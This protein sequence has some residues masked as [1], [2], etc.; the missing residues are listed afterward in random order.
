[1]C[2]VLHMYMYV[3]QKSMTVKVSVVSMVPRAL[4][5]STRLLVDVTLALLASS[6][7]QVQTLVLNVSVCRNRST[8]VNAVCLIPTYCIGVADIDDC[9]SALCL[10]GATCIDGVASYTC[11]C[12]PGKSG[13]AC[14]IGEYFVYSSVNT[15]CYSTL[16]NSACS[17]NVYCFKMVASSVFLSA[18][19]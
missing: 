19:F 2:V 3:L 9:A 10:N 7:K 5:T 13:I 4:M 8:E 16:A 14:E 12:P 11:I 6:D 17:Y 1:M 15:I 18:A